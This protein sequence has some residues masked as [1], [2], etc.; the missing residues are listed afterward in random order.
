A[1]GITWETAAKDARYV[2]YI[3]G[4]GFGKDAFLGLG[5]DPGAVGDSRPFTVASADGQS[6][7]EPQPVEVTQSL[8][9]A[10]LAAQ[11][12]DLKGK[13]LPS[14]KNMLRRFAYGNNRYVAVGDR[15]RRSVS[16]DAREW[17]DTPNMKAVD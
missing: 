11:Q 3:R 5:G 13:P 16:T 2:N 14:S 9:S 1:D 6:W 15:G 4:V 17:T 12:P 7:T 10:E 8:L